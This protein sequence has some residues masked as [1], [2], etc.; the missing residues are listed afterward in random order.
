MNSIWLVVG[1]LT[2]F[3]V[4]FWLGRKVGLREGVEKGFKEAP[5]EI[6]RR[7]LEIGECQICGLTKNFHDYAGKF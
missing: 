3:L 7:S 1:G 2:I 4:G 5:L 6:K